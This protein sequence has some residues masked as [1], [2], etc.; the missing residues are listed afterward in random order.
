MGWHDQLTSFHD[1]SKDVAMVTVFAQNGIPQLHST[2][3]SIQ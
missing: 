3:T 1:H 2:Q